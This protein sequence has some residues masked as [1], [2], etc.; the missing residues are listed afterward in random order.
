LKAFAMKNTNAALPATNPMMD[1]AIDY[2]NRGW[3]VFPC[4]PSTKQPYTTKG[5][6]D[7][8]TDV[9]QICD[10][11]TRYPAAMVGLPT[12]TVSG[13]W[14]LDID[15]KPD[16]NGA[17]ELAKLEAANGA[18]PTTLTAST[19]SGG[20]HYYFRYAEGVKNRGALN[21]ES[22]FA[23]KVGMSSRRVPS[24]TMGAITT[25]TPTLKNLLSHQI[26]FWH[27]S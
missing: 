5:F 25:G 8:T 6:K 9:N 18:L 10:W 23:V 21:R 1:A 26:G 2:S 4:D 12:G 14:V 13:L 7:A 17:I 3:P 22:T 24:E 20:T 11:W 19:P 15:V 16:A 27:L